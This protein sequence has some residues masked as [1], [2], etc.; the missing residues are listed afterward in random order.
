MRIAITGAAGW[1]GRTMTALLGDVHEL[2]L[3]DS[4]APSDATVFDPTSPTG[5]SPAPLDPQHPYWQVDIV[6]ETA[7]TAP[8]EDVEVVIHLAGWPTGE[9]EHARS[10]M[11]TNVMGT[12]NV[13]ETGR[14]CGVRRVVNA[15]SINAFGSIYWR[16]S[17]NP[18]VRS[19]LPLKEDEPR[20]PE[21]PYSLSKGTSEDIGATFARAFG[22]E[23]VNLR[24]AG[25]WSNARYEQELEGGL[26]D[27][28]GWADDLFQWVHID[29]VA[30]GIRLATETQHVV[31]APMVLG[32]ADTKAPEPTMDLIR[33]F[34]PEL[35]PLLT[36]P[37]PGRAP[38]ISI[39]RAEHALGY[40]PRYAL[41]GAIAASP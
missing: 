28:D 12:F 13:Y 25:V 20:V 18:P 11:T 26:S 35:E 37:L 7:L 38:L 3:I 36:E 5:R 19:T 23:A 34:R 6:D 22:V 21:D 2:V 4:V 9:W 30:A 33:R 40:R 8:F 39:A 29:D 14:A 1:I 16:V 27:S 31:S 10:I 17:A 32:A 41:D 24:F 15:S